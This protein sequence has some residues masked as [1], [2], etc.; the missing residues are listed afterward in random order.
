M[1]ELKITDISIE[2]R[3]FHFLNVSDGIP[4]GDTGF[5]DVPHYSATIAVPIGSQISIENVQ[6]SNVYYIEN[7][8]IIP[9]Q[10]F[11]NPMYKFDMDSKFYD[12]S[13]RKLSYPAEIFFVSDIQPIRDYQYVTVKLNPIRYFPAL[14]QI[15]VVSELR[16]TI[17]HISDSAHPVYNLNPTISAAF[18]P[19]Y[20]SLISNYSQIRM[21]DPVYQEPSIL[22]LY[23][24]A[25]TGNAMTAINNIVN[26]KR[27]MGFHVQAF[28][29]SIT[30][31]GTP[32]TATIR[33]YIRDAYNNWENPPEWV[34]LIGH[35]VAGG[36]VIPCFLTPGWNDYS[37]TKMYGNDTNGD[38]FIGRI[39]VETATD[40][41]NFWNKVN[42]Y[43]TNILNANPA[44][45]QW[46]NSS[47]LV[48]D[49]QHS[50][51]ST[52]INNRYIKS[53]IEDYDPE[54]IVITFFGSN[55]SGETQ[56]SVLN[57]GMAHYNYRGWL[58]MSGLQSRLSFL[59]NANRPGTYVMI[60]CSTGTFTGGP[61]DVA[62]KLVSNNSPAGA[63]T[64][65]GMSVPTT[66]TAFNNALCAA[67]HYGA[68][69]LDMSTMGQAVLFA[70][71][72]LMIA[73]PGNSVA[74]NS[75]HWLNLFGDPS[76]YLHKTMPRT[77]DVEF[78]ESIATGT[79]AFRFH[80][81]DDAGVDVENA[82]VT[83]SDANTSYVSKARS[84]ANG[85]VYLPFNPT[86]VGNYFFTV[87][88]PGFVNRSRINVPVSNEQPVVS[89]VDF[90]IDDPAPEG[91]GNG[92]INPGEVISLSIV[93]QNFLPTNVSD[94]V[95]TLTT[96]SDYIEI[97]TST[98]D[99]TPSEIEAGLSQCY[100][101]IFT[102]SVSPL[103]PDKYRIP[104][105]ISI[106]DGDET[107]LSYLM[108]IVSSIDVVI[109]G[110]LTEDLVSY[111]LPHEET[112]LFFMLKNRG[113]TAS[114]DLTAT[115]VSLSPYI[116]IIVDE[117]S[118]A[119]IA[120]S[121]TESHEQD[122]F[123]VLV[124]ASIIPGLTLPVELHISNDVGYAEI[125][126]FE[127]L[128]GDKSVSD[129]TGPCD[130]GY[131]IYDSR[132]HRYIQRPVYNWIDISEIGENTGIVDISPLQ[133]EDSKVVNLPFTA[134]FYGVDYDVITICSNGWFA[135]GITEQKD[136]RN[137]PLPGPVAPKS[138]VAAY[139][140]D[141]A[142]GGTYGGAIYTYYH[143][144]MNA[145]I[146]SYDDVRCVTGYPT[147]NTMTVEDTV[148]FQI[149]IYD[150][151]HH[152]TVHGDSQIKIQYKRFHPG[153]PGDP[154][155][156]FNFIT[157]G[158]QDYT[159]TRGLTYVYNNVHTLGS[160][161][162]SDGMAILITQSYPVAELS[163]QEQVKPLHSVSLAQNYP[164]P[165]NP[166]TTIIF[167]VGAI[168]TSSIKIDIYN[169]RGQ[170]VRSLI[171]AEFT[172]GEYSVVWNGRDDSGSEV[173]SGIYFYQLKTEEVST[174]RKMLLIK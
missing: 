122:K 51:I 70:K 18:E 9:V 31:A 21:L 145:F 55:L 164:N 123:S 49:S 103:A 131:L 15:E 78:P 64:A 157:V 46:L 144:D 56:V 108:P 66:H 173:S 27:R 32:N 53:L 2:G 152:E 98:V 121:T 58:G 148:S 165:F 162:L 119:S 95:A 89:V 74:S 163:E 8:N 42:L 154:A 161:P 40:I 87:S 115:L 113:T 79:Q 90:T 50:G 38:I 174:T 137:K 25:P 128:V 136:F 138:M 159:E 65:I 34:L 1:P 143:E 7:L 72:Y 73:Y 126:A 39:S 106:T 17:C 172:P 129:P 84:D 43:V 14:Q 4:S 105:T 110:F 54:N 62:T 151:A 88:K 52:F 160:H 92:V 35:S 153:V 36:F 116:E 111:L 47:Y 61:T 155:T 132:D 147:I 23:G 71:H 33:Q 133:E 60:T 94:L 76:I 99:L 150:P 86:L 158:F 41:V 80:I 28:P 104:L 5:P 93:L 10:N 124:N 125:L 149:I 101:D 22:I 85:I 3:N 139:W 19:L 109:A 156:P 97:L 118:I 81:V 11:Q 141:L 45:N 146:I 135:F 114:G 24:G 83:I 130:Y 170:R 140:T 77:F 6:M 57:G 75:N 127:I 63:M 67:I 16:M 20:E 171:D 134:R 142:V 107:W 59:S 96:D 91:N 169:I 30:S 112:E 167:S 48:S 102:F 82:V 117:V 26:L 166:N 37:Y 120:P 13:D 100:T 29:T 68:Y 44:Q 69:A 168:S 12:S